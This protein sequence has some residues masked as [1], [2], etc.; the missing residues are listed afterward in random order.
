MATCKKTRLDTE[1]ISATG[2]LAYLAILSHCTFESIK[3]YF[4]Y[5]ALY[6][7][8]LIKTSAAGNTYKTAMI[9]SPRGRIYQINPPL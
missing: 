2:Q 8:R 5:P 1:R 7:A 9:F 3:G 4:I 6:P